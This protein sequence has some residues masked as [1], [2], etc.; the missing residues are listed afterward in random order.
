MHPIRLRLDACRTRGMNKKETQ[1]LRRRK[2]ILAFSE[3]QTLML[4]KKESIL[5]CDKE[6][7]EHRCLLLPVINRN[8]IPGTI[9]GQMLAVN[10]LNGQIIHH[11]TEQQQNIKT[12]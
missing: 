2:I 7:N 9:F 10:S 5:G 11:I 8:S 4:I 6:T 1:G 3:K 12:I